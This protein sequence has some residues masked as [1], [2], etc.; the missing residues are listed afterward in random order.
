[1]AQ[2]AYIGLFIFSAA[3]TFGAS[4]RLLLTH[5]QLPDRLVIFA[6]AAIAVGAGALLV[7]VA[8]AASSVPA[9]ID[10]TPESSGRC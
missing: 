5:S 7:W 9:C 8:A 3:I 1:M 6:A 10:F 4:R 2:L